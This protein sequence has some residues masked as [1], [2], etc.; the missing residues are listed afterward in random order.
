MA[1]DKTIDV[2]K[3]D[4]W[5]WKVHRISGIKPFLYEAKEWDKDSPTQ[6]L[7]T[8][9]GRNILD[10]KML[11]LQGEEAPE[12]LMLLLKNYDDKFN[13]I[14]LS[15]SAEKLSFLK[16]IVDKEAKYIVSQ[17]ER[18]FELYTEVVCVDMIHDYRIRQN[19]LQALVQQL[20]RRSN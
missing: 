3:R 19:T 8:M 5:V 7:I 11:I 9:E 12:Q 14:I 6:I 15:T 2:H 1:K 13:K 4:G 17:V 18:N 20:T 16:C 10:N